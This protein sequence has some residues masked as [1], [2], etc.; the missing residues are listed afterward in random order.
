MKQITKRI[1][2]SLIAFVMLLSLMPAMTIATSAAPAD[3]IGMSITPLS[4][5]ESSREGEGNA[6]QTYDIV[7]YGG[8]PWRVLDK[9]Y[10][11]NK[12]ADGNAKEGAATGL[13]LLSDKAYNVGVQVYSAYTDGQNGGYINSDIR[14]YLTGNGTYSSMRPLSMTGDFPRSS[15]T[16]STPNFY[17]P[18]SNPADGYYERHWYYWIRKEVPSGSTPVP[19]TVYY[20]KGDNP[21]YVAVELTASEEQFNGADNWLPGVYYKLEGEDY[22]LCTDTEFNPGTYYYEN[23]VYTPADTSGGFAEG[24][25]YYYFEKTNDRVVAQNGNL[26]GYKL[27]RAVYYAGY[28]ITTTNNILDAEI[29]AGMTPAETERSFAADHNISASEQ[30]AILPVSQDKRTTSYN[31]RENSTSDNGYQDTN[32]SSGDA[33]E[34]DTFFLLSAQEVVEYMPYVSTRLAR[35]TNGSSAGWWLR[36]TGNSSTHEYSYSYVGYINHHFG[37]DEASAVRPAV[38]LN[39]DSVY[40]ISNIADYGKTGMTPVTKGAENKLTLKDDSLTIQVDALECIGQGMYRIRYSNAS[41][42]GDNM[43]IAL[44]TTNETGDVV[45]DYAQLDAVTSTNGSAV[46][47]ATQINAS[48]KKV[49]IFLEEDSGKYATSLASA[50]HTMAFDVSSTFTYTENTYFEVGIVSMCTCMTRRS[51]LRPT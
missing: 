37:S 3:G 41:K 21:N 40:Y 16:D 22:V 34:N 31:P 26:A 45:Y 9:A 4:N 18:H 47:D 39:P 14:T 27:I 30:A 2:S 12:D 33:M 36:S 43:H 28:G 23:V 15:I 17:E 5:I 35:L 50:A 24:T 49:Q 19:G 51:P 44:I 1:M 10:A 38:V 11:T 25:T 7:Y 32:F 42:T 46:F 8:M 29:V 6:T 20:V 48:A 13:L